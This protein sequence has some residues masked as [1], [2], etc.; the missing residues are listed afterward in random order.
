MTCATCCS[1]DGPSV[2][3]SNDNKSIYKSS[4]C[5]PHGSFPQMIVIPFFKHASQI[6]PNCHF[7]PKYKTVLALFVFYHNWV[8]NFGDEGFIAR[9]TLENVMIKWDIN[10]KTSSKGYDIKGNRIKNHKI[11]GRV[12]SDTIIWVWKGYDNKI[13]ES[14]LIHELVHLV[15]RA[16]H[17]GHGDPDHEGYKYRGW[18]PKHTWM[19]TQAKQMLHSLGL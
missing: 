15:L 12:E 13:S 7:Y 1:G 10:K 3:L 16:E 5:N 4:V 6:V 14:A 11:I 18:T 8:E 17:G 2:F 9:K 19:I